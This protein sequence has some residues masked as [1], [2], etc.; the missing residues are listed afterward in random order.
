M[1][2]VHEQLGVPH[3]PLKFQPRGP[4]ENCLPTNLN[5]NFSQLYTL[6]YFNDSPMCHINFKIWDLVKR[7]PW[8][9][10]DPAE[11]FAVG[12]KPFTGFGGKFP[13]KIS[14]IKYLRLADNEFSWLKQFFP[15]FSHALF[16]NSTAFLC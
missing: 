11:I 9:F 10:T 6:F 5:I 8:L 3:L 16:L 13:Q 2:C 1:Y 7:I 12:L 15:F 4:L 14:K